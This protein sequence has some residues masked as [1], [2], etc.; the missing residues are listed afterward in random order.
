MINMNNDTNNSNQ[1][2][3]SMQS[4][5]EM[6][7]NQALNNPNLS[8]G[9]GVNQQ[10]I[11][12]QPMS[13]FQQ[14]IMQESDHKPMN[15]FE[16]SNNNQ[17]INAY[18]NI[19]PDKN[20]NI[21]ERSKKGNKSIILIV[22]AIIVVLFAG[23]L[24]FL[25][26][27]SGKNSGKSLEESL[28]SSN[29]FFLKKSD[30][31]YALF[32]LDGK[33]LTDYTFKSVSDFVNGAAK[34]T[35]KDE[36]PGVISTSGKMIINYGI[37]KYLHQEGPFYNCVDEEYNDNV[38]DS[39]GKT[40]LKGKDLEITSFIG[41]Y[42]YAIIEDENAN[43]YTVYDYK[44]NALAS[45]AVADDSD[46]DSPSANSEGNYVSIFYNNK[47]YIF[48]VA[49]SKLVLSFADKQ[50]FCVNKV[51]ENNSDEFILNACSS[52]NSSVDEYAYKLVRN[53][54]VVY[55]KTSKSSGNLYFEGDN[56][57]LSDDFEYVLDAQGNNALKI[58]YTIFKDY[59][60]YIKQADGIL[61]GA[62]L[63]VD[64][65]L[66]EK[67]KCDNI[68]GGYAKHGVYLLDHCSGYGDGSKM[69]IKY[70][71]TRINDKT[72]KRAYEFDKNGYAVVS[73]DTQN[74]YVINLKGEKV[75]GNYSTNSSAEKIYA[76]DGADNLYCGTNEDG[77]ESIFEINGDKLVTGKN[78]NTEVSNGTVYAI[79]ENDSGYTILDLKKK[80]D[81]IT[82]DTKPTT[83]PKYFTI[84]KNSKTQ[85][86]S[87]TTGKMFYEE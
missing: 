87:Y 55:T 38:M 83:Y 64:G 81:I 86:Y 68:Q 72:Y 25:K 32:N 1:D 57:I 24:I 76:I 48:D 84:S 53:G 3:Y 6:L 62:E 46:V 77:T 54:K 30:G 15:T 61:N 70:D 65:Q 29:S 16:S 40:I 36:Q 22:I 37:C 69:Y 19:Q 80:K 10:P 47:N 21:E 17:N 50:H 82:V 18:Q 27:N 39:S 58:S 45:F 41:E 14:P 8:Q 33:Q 71:G 35:N 12:S 28:T 60:N 59:K 2:S 66:K 56:V 52:W 63:Y 74:F 4:N 79:I 7:G 67:I 26:I 73:D 11:N 85:Y 43:K 75:S 31:L 20:F 78:I 23:A 34:V 42:Q 49:K 13:N 9:M 44:G 5:N 51:N